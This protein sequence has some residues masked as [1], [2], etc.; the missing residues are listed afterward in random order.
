MLMRKQT[1]SESAF[2]P[3]SSNCRRTTMRTG[4]GY[5]RPL[6]FPKRAVHARWMLAAGL[7]FVLTRVTTA[8]QPAPQPA[9]VTYPQVSEAACPAK[10]VSIS[11]RAGNAV[12]AV[13]RQPPG[14]GP[15]PAILLLHGGLSPYAVE[16]L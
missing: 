5:L 10:I 9:K 15:F 16:K 1:K 4:D 12:T 7:I 3:V 14:A 8:D 11:G 6:V 13:V 2:G